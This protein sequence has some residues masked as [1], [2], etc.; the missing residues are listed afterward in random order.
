MIIS[1]RPQSSLG[2]EKRNGKG[3]SGMQLKQLAYF[4]A[5]IEAGSFS[6]AAKA[7]YTSQPTLSQSI[8]A[9]EKELGFEL[10]FRM[11]TGVVPTEMGAI[12]LD[13]AKRILSLE[14]ELREKW[15]RL[16]RQRRAL[17]GTV[18]LVAFPSAYAFVQER[19][20]ERSRFSYPNL[21]WQLLESRG[22]NI[23][24]IFEKHQ[25]DLCVGDYVSAEEESFL[26]QA[27]ADGLSVAPLCGD[28]CKVAVSRRNPLSRQAD[29]SREDAE[30]LSLAYYSG[31]D[32]VADPHFTRFFHDSLAIEFHSFE[33]IV[34][35]AVNNIAV[36]PVAV[37][38]TR[39]GLLGRYGRDCVSF[40]TVE[41]FSLPVTHCLLF[42]K[43]AVFTPEMEGARAL[44]TQAYQE[45][46]GVPV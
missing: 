13:D 45:L 44:I 19:I 1:I 39:R 16:D 8:Q 20:V 37:R 5:I 30:T 4:A 43:D 22:S 15:A 27:E 33:R 25:A 34:E 31:G 40:L 42:A 32:D 26:R 21:R 2:A 36:S 24:H 10:L 6:G 28:L 9:L 35:A 29:I 3:R 11:S 23:R 7:L 38:I 14:A 17:S 12:V 41:G 18:R 46:D